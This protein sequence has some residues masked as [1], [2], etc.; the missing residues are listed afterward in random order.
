MVTYHVVPLSGEKKNQMSVALASVVRLTEPPGYLNVPPAKATVRPAVP[1]LVSTKVN[2]V[3]LFDV[4][5]GVAKVIV[6]LPVKVAVNT[7]P[8][9][10]LMV[11]AVP[12]LPKAVTSSEKAPEKN[13]LES[14]AITEV[15][16]ESWNP[17]V[18]FA[19]AKVLLVTVLVLLSVRMFDGVM[20]SDKLAMGY[21]S[22]AV[23]QA[24][25]AICGKSA[26]F[27]MSRRA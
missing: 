4:L 2:E 11:T 19:L 21:A 20:M 15:P 12:V 7:L 23:G 1:S 6:A 13:W 10:Q 17:V 5:L 16:P 18:T 3:A 27:V 9:L 26:W 25:S 14:K 24:S 8:L 22:G